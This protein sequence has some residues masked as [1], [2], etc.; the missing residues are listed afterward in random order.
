MIPIYEIDNL[1]GNL[2]VVFQKVMLILFTISMILLTCW[3]ITSL[4]IWLFRS[5]EE[6]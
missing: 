2:D 3:I 6:I 4:L 5:K 1:T